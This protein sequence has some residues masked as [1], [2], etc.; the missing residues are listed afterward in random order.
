MAELDADV[1][2]GSWHQP[3]P[4]SASVTWS[5]TS[6]QGRPVNTMLCSAGT[7]LEGAAARALNVRRVL[8]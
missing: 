7:H 4:A 8:S 6:Q 2:P 5:R 1:V 3:S